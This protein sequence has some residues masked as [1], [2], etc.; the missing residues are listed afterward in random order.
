MFTAKNNRR[1]KHA[2]GAPVV[3]HA[4][5]TNVLHTVSEIEREDNLKGIFYVMGK[6]VKKDITEPCADY[7]PR[8]GPDKK[9][10][11]YFC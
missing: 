5:D 9:V 3:G 11:N 4:A 8:D 2:D 1:Y 6:I 10:L 7:E